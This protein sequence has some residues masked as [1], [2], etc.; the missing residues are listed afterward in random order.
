[1]PIV[2]VNRQETLPENEGK[3]REALFSTEKGKETFK[4]ENPSIS[5]K[6]LQKKVSLSSSNVANKL[7][8]GAE[9]KKTIN[10]SFKA[11]K[12]PKTPSK[13]IKNSEKPNFV[14]T[15]KKREEK[16]D[17]P[18]EKKEKPKFYSQLETTGYT[19]DY[20]SF[21][22]DIKGGMI[23]TN[24]NRYIYIMEIFAN[25]FNE[26]GYYEQLR[27]LNTFRGMINISPIY[28]HLKCITE[29]MDTSTILNRIRTA[30][31]DVSEKRRQIRSNYIQNVRRLSSS[32]T[33]NYRYFYIFEYE[34]N[35]HG[36][37]SSDVQEVYEQMMNLK[38]SFKEILNACNNMVAEPQDPN[39]YT[40]DIL[41][42]LLNRNSYKT[43]N[44]Y[45]RIMRINYDSAQAGIDPDFHSYFSP[46][47]IVFYDK[48]FVMMDG[49]YYTWFAIT[50]NGYP[51]A[52][53]PDWL[54][55]IRA[56]VNMDIDF[57]M[58]KL[59]HQTTKERM[60]KKRVWNVVSA[61]KQDNP[62]KRENLLEKANVA[63]SIAA[64]MEQGEDLFDCCTVCTLY[65]SEP[66]ALLQLRDKIRRDYSGH[67]LE[68]EPCF[69]DCEEYFQMTL[70]FL[71]FENSVFRRNKRN[72]I[73]S[74]VRNIYCFTQYSSFDQ[75]EHSIVIG[76]NLE[77]GTLLALDKFNRDF[78][79][80]PHIAVIGTSGSGK[81]ALEMAFGRRENLMG[82]RTF[83]ICPLKAH[84]YHEHSQEM[85]GS[86]IR[87]G[88]K[89]KEH[90]N[91]MEL[92]PEM[93][94]NSNAEEGSLIQKSV[95]AK[96]ITALTT[97]LRILTIIEKHSSYMMS[98]VEM[99]RI[100]SI[101]EQLYADFGITEDNDSIWLDKANKVKKHMPILSYWEERIREDSL[102]ERFADLLIPFTKGN[103]ANYNEQTNI[104]I[105]RDCI[106]CD[107]D[108]D[109]IGEE[110][111][112]AIMFLAFDLCNSIIKSDIE[113]LA[114][115]Y[116]DEE[117]VM[118]LD[119]IVAKYI[120]ENSRILRAYGG[121]VVSASQ[122]LEE[123]MDNKYGRAVVA[124]SSIKI[125]M[126]MEP[127]EV[128]IVSKTIPLDERDKNY[129]T[130][131]SSGNM[132]II[133]KSHKFRC[134]LALTFE[135]L[136]VYDPDP[137]HKKKFR[138]LA[139]QQ[140]QA[141]KGKPY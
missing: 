119:E 53:Y 30:C 127:S 26:Q 54:T 112:P 88:P 15:A 130:Q 133:T 41:Y 19:Q 129:L 20:F 10:S 36:Y 46:R 59:P 34:G 47:G 140:K 39:L 56:E 111:L 98:T 118:L 11:E 55:D 117:W 116:I 48:E 134:H 131:A 73:S 2:S 97:W 4:T 71:D 29:Q 35:T 105:H 37:R 85:E 115:L 125:L 9:M 121:S 17:K 107:V 33:I 57:F 66:K 84:E 5:R 42:H 86:Y 74:T 25:N 6:K 13:A 80:N 43:E 38:M 61:R 136:A 137:K 24:R 58:K 128:E 79:P 123:F 27:I 139:K 62:E 16:K 102:V 109:D 65:G 103:Y 3:E 64:A 100:E 120:N 75:T 45:Q 50:D 113:T 23:I 99:N 67:Q 124:N 138:Q 110:M 21:I 135:E 114:T 95:L 96:K 52:V 122:Q 83:Y 40:L 44:L 60:K 92:F 32:Q 22:K 101:L 8:E 126:K 77:H 91:I 106:V 51:G 93:V 108:K 69:M 132:L 72:M 82:I 28:V 31:P 94:M 70:P 1:M 90:Y 49:M 104:D 76:P 78:Y 12:S 141:E 81:S 7:K 18:S 87:F 68:T 63:G 14:E 89:A